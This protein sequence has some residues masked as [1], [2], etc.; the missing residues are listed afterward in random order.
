MQRED[1]L[2][3]KVP[4]RVVVTGGAGY[5]GSHVVKMLVKSGLEVLILDNLSTTSG[6]NLRFGKFEK[7]D[8]GKEERIFQIFSSYKPQAVMHFAAYIVVP[9]SVEKPFKY[10]YNNVGNTLRLLSA[11]QRAQVKN[12]IF[13]SSAAVYG[14]PKEVPV[15]EEADLNPISPYGESKA[16]VEKILKDMAMAKEINYISLRYFNVAG[17]DPEGELGPSYNQPTHLI[18]RALK[19]AKG[20]LPYLEIYGT[21]YPTPDGTCIRDYI[22]VMDLAKAHLLALD[23]LLSKG[24]SLVLNCGYGKGYSVREVINTAQKVTAINFEV[25]ETKRRPGD[26][27][28][29]IADNTK[30]CKI[31]NFQPEYDDLELIIKHT[32]AW[33]QKKR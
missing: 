29:L 8:L 21:D 24:E 13:S 12:F 25:R 23:Y 27:P 2:G 1:K 31:L 32:W 7:V 20:E 26:P 6:E 30:I 11:M 10:Y 5:I 22:H 16:M 9:E 3:N 17:A 15:K 33:E 19:T 18:L 28:V 14:I 4:L